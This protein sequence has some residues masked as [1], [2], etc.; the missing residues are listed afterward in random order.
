MVTV[1]DAFGTVAYRCGL[2]RFHVIQLPHWRLAISLY[3]FT[4]DA[5]CHFS[6]LLL[7]HTGRFRQSI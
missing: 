3:N 6:R 7:R 5:G 2:F 4:F 1:C